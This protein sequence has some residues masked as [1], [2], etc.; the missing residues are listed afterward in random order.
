MSVTNAVSKTDP[1]L[2]YYHSS[3]C[4]TILRKADVFI[5]SPTML[6]QRV[7]WLFKHQWPCYFQ[8]VITRNCSIPEVSSPLL[9]SSSKNSLLRFASFSINPAHSQGLSPLRFTPLPFYVSPRTTPK[10]GLSHPQSSTLSIPTCWG[11]LGTCTTTPIKAYQAHLPPSLSWILLVSRLLSHFPPICTPH[12]HGP[13][14]V[15][16]RSR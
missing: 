3:T 8:H 10:S 14:R 15:T 5:N 4:P 7:P 11:V 6:S 13:L 12:L 1:K 9:P 2:R 16:E